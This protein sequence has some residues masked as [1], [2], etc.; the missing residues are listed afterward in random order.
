M[1]KLIG[2]SLMSALLLIG[3][4]SFA[5]EKKMMKAENGKAKMEKMAADLGLSAEQTEQVKAIFKAEKTNLKE[6]KISKEEMQK[7]SVEDRKIESA[8]MKLK[9]A[10]AAKATKM[11]LAEVLS[12]E[13]LEKF[14]A[15]QAEQKEKRQDLKKERMEHKPV[16]ED[17]HQKEP[18]TAD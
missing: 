17:M 2:I 4:S 3:T 12:A 5:Q 11:K 6:A 18:N 7:L 1:K 8:K 15:I 13:Q 14:E 16:Q 10:E 9:R